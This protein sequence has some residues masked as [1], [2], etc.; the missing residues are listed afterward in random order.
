MFIYLRKIK[1][2]NRQTYPPKIGVIGL[3]LLDLYTSY[4]QAYLK[5]RVKINY[6][7]ELNLKTMEDNFL[8]ET[9]DNF[10]RPTT[11]KFSEVFKIEQTKI[12]NQIVALTAVKVG[13]K[14][15]NQG[16]TIVNGDLTIN[17]VSIFDLFDKQLIGTTN[18]DNKIF[19]VTGFK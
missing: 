12:G 6:K 3:I 15:L 2:N 10:H 11:K 17:N 8:N 9:F 16:I 7:I 13:D 1:Y 19:N 4:T 18:I 5:Y 14:L